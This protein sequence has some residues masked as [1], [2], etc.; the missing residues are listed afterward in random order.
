ML[1]ELTLLFLLL[2]GAAKLE[3]PV[4][5]DER[6]TVNLPLIEVDHCDQ[7][8]LRSFLIPP[9]FSF[10]GFSFPSTFFDAHGPHPQGSLELTLIGDNSFLTASVLSIPLGLATLKQLDFFNVDSNRVLL[11]TQQLI[12]RVGNFEAH[13]S[14]KW[15]SMAA[16]PQTSITFRLGTVIGNPATITGN[17]GTPPPSPETLRIAPIPESRGPILNPT[18]NSSE[19][20]AESKPGCGKITATSDHPDN[21]WMLFVLLLLWGSLFRNLRARSSPTE[22]PEN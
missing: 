9:G 6:G 18:S 2:N 17:P 21:W 5:N 22:K 20:G 7:T 14:I 4:T 10:L 13:L 12:P 15:G 8:S 1:G 11:V 3:P 16:C 19:R